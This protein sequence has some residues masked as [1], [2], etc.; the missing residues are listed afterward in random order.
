MFFADYAEFDI[1]T[2]HGIDF[3]RKRLKNRSLSYKSWRNYFRAF[4]DRIDFR[5]SQKGKNV[6]L[7]PVCNS[8][9]SLRGRLILEF[10]PISNG[11][12]L[13]HVKIKVPEEIAVFAFIWCSFM[14]FFLISAV[15]NGFIIGIIVSLLMLIFFF[16]LFYFMR[17]SAE[18]ETDTIISAFRNIISDDYIRREK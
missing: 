18:N 12:T 14:I 3:M 1:Q 4:D 6:I 17:K 11:E 10:E 9:N 13:I 8:R 5:Y 2:P 16:S 15:L 7:Y